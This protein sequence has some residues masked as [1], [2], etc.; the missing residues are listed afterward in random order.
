MTCIGRLGGWI[1]ASLLLTPL[2]VARAA[3]PDFDHALLGALS[4]DTRDGITV[5]VAVPGA[6]AVDTI[7]GMPAIEK[8]IQPVYVEIENGSGAPLWYMPITM[9]ETY[10]SPAELAYRFHDSLHP[11]RSIDN[12]KRAERLSMP[13]AIAAGATAS[14]FVYTHLE[15]GLKFVT[16]GMLKDGNEIDVRFIIPVAGPAYATPQLGPNHMP[17]TSTV[18]DVDLPTLKARIEA[19]PCCTTN[20]AGDR[21]GDPLNLVVIGNGIDTLFPFV[22]RGW[23][24][25]EPLDLHSAIDTAK[26]FVIGT[27]YATS[28]VSPLY[29]F[30]RHQD[31]A[32]EK[33]RG[34]I[35]ERNHMRFWLTPLRYEGQNVWIGQISRDIGVELTD[36]SWYL[37]THKIGPEVDFDRDYL[38]QDMLKSGAIAHFG[39]A[40][41]V[42]VSRLPDPH[43]NLTGDPYVTD[44]LRLVVML[45]V[46]GG[47]VRGAEALEWAKLPLPGQ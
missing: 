1:L 23:H 29:A 39:Y 3:P 4:S 24:L 43:V 30:G 8:G 12:A 26:S 11:E 44:G 38:L 35:N 9:D 27:E 46:D 25:T 31:I 7:L 47:L 13:M 19:M 33:A 18:E 21:N 40:A 34:S 20:A 28:P 42:G 37:T 2:G 32:L 5:R 16:V 15:T 45:D 10:F 22:G 41:G 14:G 17:V 36:K 6:K